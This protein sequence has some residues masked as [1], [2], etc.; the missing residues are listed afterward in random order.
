[1]FISCVYIREIWNELRHLVNPL[2]NQQNI[3]DLQ[4]LTFNFKSGTYDAEISWLLGNYVHEV[5]T[6]FIK[7]GR[8]IRRAELFGYLKFKFKQD[9]LGARFKMKNIPNL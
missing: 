8:V 5:W 9:Q 1:M 6:T 3:L 2:L 4:L 7:K